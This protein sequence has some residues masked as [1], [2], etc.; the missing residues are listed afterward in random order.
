MLNS[1]I[2]RYQMQDR[3]RAAQRERIAASVA[4]PKGTRRVQRI[5]SVFGNVKVRRRAPSRTPR[6]VATS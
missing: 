1:E 2:G 3:L 4:T 6:V 5:S